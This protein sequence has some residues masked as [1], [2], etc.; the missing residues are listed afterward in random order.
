MDQKQT[1]A[2]KNSNDHPLHVRIEPWGD[3]MTIEPGASLMIDFN[4]PIGGVIEVESE[5][6]TIVVYGWVGSTMEL[7]R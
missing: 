1:L 4:G 2:V 5:P 7:R 6:D 3:E